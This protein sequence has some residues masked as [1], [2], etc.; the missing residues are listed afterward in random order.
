MFF[1]AHHSPIGAF[2]TFTLGQKGPK[3]GL[4]L[5]LAGPADESV[6][7]GVEEREADGRYRT[8]P[9]YGGSEIAANDYD[10]EGLSDLYFANAL[11]PFRDD[12]IAREMGAGVDE[13]CAGDLT[14]RIVSPPRAVPDPSHEDARDSLAPSVLVELTVDNRAGD[15][16]RRA[17]FGYGGSDRSVGMRILDEPGLVGVGQ[18]TSVAIATDDLDV[19]AGL[20]W[21]PEAVLSPHL[22][23]NLGFMLGSLGLLVGVVEPGE[24]RTFQFA[25]AFFREG[26]ATTGIRTRYLYRRWFDRVEDVL[27]HAL[28]RFDETVRE[29]KAFDE[30][31]KRDLSPERAFMTGHAIRSYFGSTQLLE[32]E[33]GRPLW[34]VHE[35]EYRM[36]NTFDLTVDQAFFELALNPWTVR[37]VLDLFVERYAYQDGTR[38]PGNPEV[39]PGGIAFTHDMGVSNAFSAPGRSGYEQAG[40]H[41]CFSYMSGEELMNWTLTAGLYAFH[42][43]DRDWVASHRETFLACLKSLENRDHPQEESR[44]GVMGL[45]GDR[46]RGGAEITTYDSLDASLGQA[47]NNLYLAVKGWATYLFLE[48]LLRDLGETA[49]SEAAKRQTERATAT[50]IASADNDG[51]LPAVIGEGVEARIIP[52][53]EALVYPFVAGLP[54]D[55]DLQRVLARHFEAVL[56]QGV[57]RFDDGGWR[58]SST[59]RNS[60]LSKIYLCQYVA[61]RILGHA[62]DT[63]ADRAH[64]GWLMDEENAYYAWSDQMLEG[65]AVGSRYYPRGVTSVLWLARGERPLEEIQ[66]LLGQGALVIQR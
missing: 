26:T 25:V 65:K 55:A 37:N 21:Q 16:P 6:Y 20:A 50:I 33:D 58:L 61:E 10:V 29:A 35:G 44:N 43:G 48:K 5:E 24:I 12:E 41:G 31:L 19:Y 40:L 9:F 7:V 62:P 14:F 54:I 51:L 45:D 60:W 57:C 30:R 46:C 34:V 15:K 66:N 36:M 53:I 59:S 2:A 17:F 47:R 3:G 8:L 1:N 13:W 27:K 4:G 52:A 63:E 64:L 49:D 56:K 22:R 28:G 23:E 11:V 32:R 39:Q 42:T 38:F 18:G